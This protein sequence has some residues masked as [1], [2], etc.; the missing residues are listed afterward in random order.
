MQRK[1]L[2]LLV[3]AVLIASAVPAVG[4]L[5][6]RSM[7]TKSVPTRSTADPPTIEIF[8]WGGAEFGVNADIHYDG[9]DA[10]LSVNWSIQVKG[11]LFGFVLKNASGVVE[12]HN[13]ESRWVSSGLFFGLGPFTVT[14]RANTV[15]KTSKGFILLFLV[16]MPQ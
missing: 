14:A 13:H 16:V 10:F 4:A 5:P 2:G 1:L 11:S 15:E 8:L 3:C 6:P 7:P 12:I 9:D